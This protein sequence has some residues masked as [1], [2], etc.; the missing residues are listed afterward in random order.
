M[1]FYPVT[2]GSN[3]FAIGAPQFPEINMKLQVNGQEKNL[4]IKANNLSEENQYVKAVY[5]DGKKVDRLFIHYFDLIKASEVLVEMADAKAMGKVHT[6]TDK[7]KVYASHGK[8]HFTSVAEATVEGYN[9]M[10]QKIMQQNVTAG[11]NTINAP[12]SGVLLVKVGNNPIEKVI[13]EQ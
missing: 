9:L 7:L 4:K 10:G 2:P 5:L 6:H 8:I 11:L 3:E 1:G 13:I 12:Q